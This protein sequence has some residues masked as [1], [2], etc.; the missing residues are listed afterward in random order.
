MS[1]RAVYSPHFQFY[2]AQNYRQ[3][4]KTRKPISEHARAAAREHMIK[5]NKRAQTLFCNLQKWTLIV[6]RLRK[7]LFS[8]VLKFDRC[9]ARKHILMRVKI[10]IQIFAL[11]SA[12]QRQKAV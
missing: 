9:R 7:K 6:S 2:G 5:V 8:F 3:P 10:Y 12:K 11:I 1:L 4:A